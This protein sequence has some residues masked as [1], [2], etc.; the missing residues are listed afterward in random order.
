MPIERGREGWSVRSFM[1][2]LVGW[3][4]IWTIVFMVLTLGVGYVNDTL[5]CQRQAL[6]RSTQRNFLRAVSKLDL[7]T[8]S[9]VD[10]ELS[11]LIRQ[12]P[13]SAM[14]PGYEDVW[15]HFQREWRRLYRK[16][17]SDEATFGR[18]TKVL[19]ERL[20]TPNCGFPPGVN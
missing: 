18:F 16:R 11:R 4:V 1:L 10:R 5:S 7:K 3:V 17:A 2:F 6:P 14:R 19:A 8:R 20:S 9:P 15:R 13:P 12:V